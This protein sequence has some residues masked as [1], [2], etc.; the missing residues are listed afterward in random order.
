MKYSN[1]GA[2]KENEK[3]SGARKGDATKVADKDDDGIVK[4]AETPVAQQGGSE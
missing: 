1:D 4:D 2:K 3:I